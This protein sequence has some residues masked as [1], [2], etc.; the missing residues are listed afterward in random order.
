MLLGRSTGQCSMLQL[1]ILRLGSQ[2]LRLGATMSQGL[3]PTLIF[4]KCSWMD[5][6]LCRAFLPSGQSAI[7]QV[8]I[9]RCLPYS[10]ALRMHSEFRRKDIWR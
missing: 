3:D 9:T 5:H 7:P 1:V 6:S 10:I 8:H 4:L 2:L